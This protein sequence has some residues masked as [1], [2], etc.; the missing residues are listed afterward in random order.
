M[1]R[2]SSGRVPNC[3]ESLVDP[4]DRLTN[5]TVSLVSGTL[6]VDLPSSKPTFTTLYN[7]TNSND[8][9]PDGFILSS[10]NTSMGRLFSPTCLRST[11]IA[12]V[13]QT[14]K[15]CLA[16]VGQEVYVILSGNTLYGT[17]S[18]AAVC[19]AARY[20]QFTPMAPVIRT[21]IISTGLATYGPS[22]G[23]ILSGSTLYSAASGGNGNA[24]TGVR[25]QHEWHRFYESV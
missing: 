12:R 4:N 24:D 16:T 14:C 6:T 20:S 21:C 25:S 22:G 7:F 5:Y 1:T 18:E 10:N 17:M 8:G 23:V 11:S 19:S 3:A 9:N 15:V 2:L 13:L